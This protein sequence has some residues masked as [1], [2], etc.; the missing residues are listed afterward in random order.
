MKSKTNKSDMVKTLKLLR[1]EMEK[2]ASM[3]VSEASKKIE[4]YLKIVEQEQQRR[5]K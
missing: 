5:N 4:S 1:A 2:L 3:Q